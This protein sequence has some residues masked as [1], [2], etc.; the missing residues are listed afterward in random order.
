MVEVNVRSSGSSPLTRGALR[1]RENKRRRG[2]LIPAHAGS[3]ALVISSLV[4]LMG[5][6]P[7]TRGALHIILGDQ[8]F[9]GLI[10][11]HA[12][13]TT[14]CSG[15]RASTRA[16]PRSRGEHPV[17][18]TVWWGRWGSSPLTRGAHDP[19]RFALTN[20]GLIPA[21]AGSTFSS[22]MRA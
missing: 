9:V 16:H 10:P 11:A 4:F 7:L 2:R 6:S 3:T 18:S 13:S 17:A 21:H 1:V 22:A 12:G 14:S 8:L 15:C 19:S 5:S 20:V